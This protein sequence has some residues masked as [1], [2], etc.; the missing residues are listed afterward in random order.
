MKK[1]R[2][3]P[4]QKRNRKT[5]IA[6]LFMLAFVLTSGTF[7]YWA[8]AVEG[9]SQDAI[10]T[11]TV[12]SGDNV[13]TTFELTNDFDSGG[14]LV[15]ANQVENSGVGAVGAIDLSFDVQWLEDEA[16]SQL[17]GTNSIGQIVISHTVV[18]TL[19]GEVLDSGLNSEIYDLVN[20]DYNAS[21]A[22]EL[23]LDADAETFAFQITLD[24]PADQDEYNLIA[25]AEISITFSYGIN[26]AAILTTDNQ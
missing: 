17:T 9:T 7:A 8:T 4:N 26:D 1:R 22:T 20:V 3:E 24:E 6:F 13:E 12:G 11:L 21:N 15:P 25:N 16:T 14:F 10:G 23:T 18:I 2:Q 5:L 19:D